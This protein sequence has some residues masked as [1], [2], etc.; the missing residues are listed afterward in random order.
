[1]LEVMPESQG[2][3]LWLR[4]RE[5]LT[6]QDYRE[7]FLPLLRTV[8]REHGKARLLFHVAPDFRGWTPGAL[9]EDMK[10][11]LKH[12]RDLEK[13]ALAGAPFWAD[14]LAKLFAHFMPGEVRTYKVE[15][16]A[17]LYQADIPGRLWNRVF[18]TGS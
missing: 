7:V 15:A 17:N 12:R 6:A 9:W 1:M 11:G 13:I 18:D 16:A 5:R 14:V 3:L 8:I 2:P 4:A 10:A